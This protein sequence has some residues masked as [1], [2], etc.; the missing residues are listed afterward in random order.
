M[1]ALSG[2]YPPAYKLPPEAPDL[3]WQPCITEEMPCDAPLKFALPP[4]SV[5]CYQSAEELVDA[6]HVY[7]LSELIDIAQRWNPDT[8]IAW[9]QAKQAAYAVGLTQ[10]GYLP[11]ISADVLSGQQHT[12]IPL[13]KALFP[14]DRVNLDTEEVL[15]SL[16]I[17]WLLFDFGQ[18]AY[19]TKS[20]YY[21]SYASNVAF[22]GAHQ[23][24]IFEVSKAYFALDAVNAQFRVAEDAL[25]NA[26]ILQDAAESKQERGLEKITEVAISRRET[27]KARYDLELAKASYNDAYHAL[28]EAMGLTPTLK[29]QIEESS[30]RPLPEELADD[31]NSYICR[32]LEKRP[33]II[34][35]FA[36][37]RA[38]SA[39]VSSAIASYGPTL[40]FRGYAYQNIG[41]LRVDRGPTTGI[42][43]PGSAFFLRFSWPLF[44]GGV[45][46][47]NLEI[48]RSLNAAAQD[49]LIK[50][51]DQAIREV[52]RAYDNVKS[53]LAEYASAQ[54]LVEA[55]TSPLMQR[56]TPTA[57]EWEHLQMQ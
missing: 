28:M 45:R 42:N 14:T 37:L 25:K 1:L 46:R 49:E 2:C 40:E 50:T 34:E 54:A 12:P 17:K 32:A 23:K 41:S 53:A 29:L 18:K 21:L 26:L 52:A 3:P 51:Q 11:L 24:L 7:N 8:R 39:A 9:E 43:R 15:P 47:Y 6:D 36:K 33:D 16:V 20:A 38:S 5:P 57:K 13:P 4:H 10:A 44:D 48:A 19:L 55:S 56:S 35:A 31:V 27:A 30:G 22:T